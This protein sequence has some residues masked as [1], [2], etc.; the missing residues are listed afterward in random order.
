MP[1]KQQLV[2]KPY[3]TNEIVHINT[4]I[5]LLEGLNPDDYIVEKI[6]EHLDKAVEGLERR[7]SS[8]VEL[9]NK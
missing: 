9:V 5:A 2:T 7:S 6:K 8:Y 1:K 4:A 3:L